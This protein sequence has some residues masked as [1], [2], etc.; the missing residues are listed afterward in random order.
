MKTF[1]RWFISPDPFWASLGRFYALVY[2]TSDIISG[3]WWHSIVSLWDRL[4]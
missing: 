1:W 2:L 3:R 4:T